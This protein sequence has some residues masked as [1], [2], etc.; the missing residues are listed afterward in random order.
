M[1][2]ATQDRLAELRSALE[3]K[4]AAN[5]E[6]IL[7]VKG[8]G[9]DASAPLVIEPGMKEAFQKNLADKREIQDEI[10][11]LME[12]A[13][14][15]D[16][17]AA[18]NG[19][20]TDPIALAVAAAIQ[21]GAVPG[22][23]Q[24]V[25]RGLGA[26]FTD[27][28]EFK[29]MIASKGF[30]MATPF[31]VKGDL[32]SYMARKDVYHDLPSGTPG[33]FG[34]VERD[35]LVP[36]PQRTARIRDLFPARPTSALTI[37]FFRQTGF[38][39]AASPVPERD[40]S[41]FGEKPQ[42]GL[43]FVGQ[44]AAVRTIAHWEAAHRTVLADEPQLQGIIENEL[45]Y[46]L[47]LHEDYQILQGTGTGEDLL[48]IL[49]TP[50]IQTYAWS[51]GDDGDNKADALRRAMTMSLLA[52]YEP[53]GVVIH[54][55]DWEDIELTKSNGPE[56][57]YLFAATI[58]DG[59]APRVWRVPLVP[60]QAIPEGTA[61]VGAFGLGA[62]LYDREQGNIRIA[63]QHSDF[64]VRN[65]VAILAEERL[66]LATKRPESFVEVTFDAAPA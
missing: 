18:L 38:T 60:T 46:G 5:E 43:A 17:L 24:K 2:T 52:L 65:A 63:E 50:G 32:G 9:E 30:T 22:S 47:R 49:N 54:D 39:N 64:F 14:T 20:A 7:S 31:E 10:K 13:E 33:T 21:S 57:M 19:K 6:I 62:Q 3:A 40:G 29:S 61:L 12:D 58:Q 11:M 45:L 23:E 51:E 25:L 36:L 37:E 28:D 41:D 66:A 59:G 1:A 26:Q 4:H 8:V 42:S 15:G 48:G 35:A 27:S 55:S 56:Q 44:Q 53:T 16:V 34:S